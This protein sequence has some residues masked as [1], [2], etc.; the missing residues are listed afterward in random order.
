MEQMGA[1]VGAAVG[2]SVAGSVSRGVRRRTNNQ[3][4][5]INDRV[6]MVLPTHLV[7]YRILMFLM[8]NIQYRIDSHYILDLEYTLILHFRTTDVQCSH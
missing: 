8:S 5:V 1:A 2:A 4:G 7:Q 6:N 3:L